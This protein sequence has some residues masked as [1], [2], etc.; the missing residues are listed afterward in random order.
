MIEISNKKIEANFN[1]IE[2]ASKRFWIVPKE[3]IYI[4]GHSGKSCWSGKPQTKHISIPDGKYQTFI[5]WVNYTHMS[6]HVSFTHLPPGIKLCKLTHLKGW[7]IFI[8][9]IAADHNYIYPAP[10]HILLHVLLM[11]LVPRV[12]YGAEQE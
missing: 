8:K 6:Y 7:M 4:L 9:E 11:P 1:K 12:Q 3:K 5:P 2:L 10:C